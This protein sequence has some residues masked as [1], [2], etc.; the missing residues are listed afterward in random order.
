[1]ILRPS[2]LHNGISYTGKT[3]SLYCIESLYIFYLDEKKSNMKIK[4]T[5]YS[6][7]K[8]D[9]LHINHA[10]DVQCCKSAV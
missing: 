4:L 3:T 1:M 5:Q 8:M 2:Y 10:V 7:S 6:T 9:L